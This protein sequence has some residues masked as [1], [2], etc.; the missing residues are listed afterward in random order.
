MENKFITVRAHIEYLDE[1]G[2]PEDDK[3]S[4]NGRIPDFC[5]YGS[6]LYRNDPIAFTVSLHDERRK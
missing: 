6:W 1:L 5:K 2:C 4:N 3:L